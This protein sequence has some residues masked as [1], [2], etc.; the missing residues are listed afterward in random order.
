MHAHNTSSALSAGLLVALCS[1]LC[2]AKQQPSSTETNAHMGVALQ[3]P[4]SWIR[5]EKE[6]R[7]GERMGRRD[8]R[9]DGEG[10]KGGRIDGE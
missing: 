3:Q 10:G 5:R 7:K 2:V 8:E 9:R 6:G 4:G 1:A